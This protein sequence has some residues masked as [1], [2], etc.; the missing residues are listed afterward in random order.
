MNNLQL[1]EILTR[2]LPRCQ[3]NFLGVFAL[4]TIP[5]LNSLSTPFCFV[6][7]THPS[8]KP[9]EHWVAFF[10]STNSLEFF[11]S[12]GLPPSIYGFTLHPNSQS[13]QTLQSLESNVCGQY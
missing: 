13:H 12:Y 11:D 5:D 10:N 6:S 4:D 3:V 7:N 1:E 9:G 8:S 2:L